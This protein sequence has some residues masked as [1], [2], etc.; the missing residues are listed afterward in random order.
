MTAEQ[1][2]SLPDAEERVELVEGALHRMS[3]AGGAH[4]AVVVQILLAVHAHV[5][6][7]GLGAVFPESTG[8]VLRRGPDTVRAPDV[9]FVA[10]HRLPARG[11][12]AGY[13][14]MAPDLAVEVLSPSNTASE[15]T[16]KVREYLAAGT[17]LV[18]VVDPA[19]HGV[20]TYERD[21]TERRLGERD[22]LAGGDVLPGF[23]HPVASLFRGLAR[24]SAR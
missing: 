3:P 20:T 23:T 16:R 15:M 7:L 17:R 12:G 11:L 1:L 6:R 5:A 18:W 14:E 24:D 4:G 8:F 2:L 9:A 22:L 13:I 21:G 10:A 19:T